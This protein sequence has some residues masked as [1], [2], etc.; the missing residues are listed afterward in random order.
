MTI[1]AK[2]NYQPEWD[3]KALGVWWIREDG[4]RFYLQGKWIEYT[5]YQAPGIQ[6][7]IAHPNSEDQP[8]YALTVLQAILDAMWEGGMRPTG[9][10]SR[11]DETQALKNHLDSLSKQLERDHAVIM[12]AVNPLKETP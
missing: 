11:N 8:Q 12:G 10:S 2:I 9:H 5:P 6:P 7:V 4:K 3:D 1:K